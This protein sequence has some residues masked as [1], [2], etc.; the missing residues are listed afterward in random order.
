MNK[1]NTQDYEI[2]VPARI[3]MSVGTFYEINIRAA[4]VFIETKIRT[5]KWV[6]CNVNSIIFGNFG[7]KCLDK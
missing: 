3:N 1:V 4:E 2:N 7:Q 6:F 5:L